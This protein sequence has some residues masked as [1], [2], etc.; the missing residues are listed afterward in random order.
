MEIY[1]INALNFSYPKSDRKVLDNVSLTIFEGDFIVLCGKSGSGKTTLLAHLKPAVTPHGQTTGEILFNQQPLTAIDERRQAAEIGFVTQ[2][3][4]NQIVTDKVWHELAFGLESLGYHQQTIRLRVAEMA[5]FFDM[6]TWFTKDVSQLSGG[7]KQLLNLASIMAMQPKVLIL[8][9]P[10]A[11]LDPI[12]AKEF[13]DTIKKINIELG[14]TVILVEHRLEEAFLLADKVIIMEAGAVVFND[15]PAAVGHQLKATHNEMLKYVPTAMQIYAKLPAT[16]EIACPITIRDGR[17][18]LNQLN[19]PTSAS[20][21]EFAKAT[22]PPTKKNEAAITVDNLY[23]KYEK[24]APDIICGLSLKVCER[25]IYALLGGNGTGKT[26]ILSLIAGLQKAYRGKVNRFGQKI[27]MLPQNPQSLFVMN[28]VKKELLHLAPNQKKAQE[29]AEFTAISQ[30]MDQHPY[31]LS[32]GEAQRLAI[33]KVL[34]SEPDILLLDEPT[35][36][37]D[38]EFKEKFGQ[39]LL[40]LKNNGTT[41][42]MVS[43]DVEFCALFADYCGLMFNGEIIASG[44][45]G[46]FFAGASF[47][48]TAANKIA[49][50]LWPQVITTSEII[51]KCQ[52]V[53]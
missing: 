52:A 48:T 42:L 23:F 6:Q 35:K 30:L 33:C 8:D 46:E 51:E 47:Y 49:R 25:E 44:T 21:G 16:N 24:H 40:K 28:T 50:H 37:L 32:G 53:W 31:D 41:I 2:N 22:P 29:L 45:P 1:Q 12:A 3:P 26:T 13:L 34:L 19:L 27:R 36:G 17:R 11:Q 20:Q 39:L 38:N 14:V 4:D 7:Q 9:E 18:F 15:T 43:H 10:T 5:T